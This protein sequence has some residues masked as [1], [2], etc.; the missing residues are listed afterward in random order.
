MGG[1]GA[2][3]SMCP[4]HKQKQT[5]TDRHHQHLQENYG[6]GKGNTISMALPKPVELPLK[7]VGVAGPVHRAARS[8][9]CCKLPV[10]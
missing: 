5:K 2:V 1:A 4:P 9:D 8:S 10:T 7:E 6:I 3:R